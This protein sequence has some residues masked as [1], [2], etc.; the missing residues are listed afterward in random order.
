M[1]ILFQ[2]DDGSSDFSYDDDEDNLTAAMKAWQ[3]P[4]LLRIVLV[5]VYTQVVVQ[6]F[7]DISSENFLGSAF[8]FFQNSTVS[9]SRLCQIVLVHTGY[10]CKLIMNQDGD[11]TD[12]SYLT[13]W[14]SND[15]VVKWGMSP[16]AY[17]TKEVD[18]A[19]M[20]S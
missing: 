19:G 9:L 16:V 11:W 4:V 17:F 3:S 14:N 10:L 8:S 5:F 13:Q 18:L 15:V 20:F 2:D 12:Y 6:N 7:S 1:L